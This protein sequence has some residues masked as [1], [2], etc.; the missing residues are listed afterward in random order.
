MS[1]LNYHHLHYFWTVARLGSVAAAAKELF[2]SQPTISAQVKALESQLGQEL[3]QRRGRGLVLTD[4]GKVAFGYADEIFRLGRELQGQMSGSARGPSRR[5]R[6][7]A[8][9]VEVLPKV[10]AE[11]LLQPAVE[12]VPSLALECREGALPDLLA[13]LALHEVDVVLSDTAATPDVRV[14]VFNHLLGET[15][16][17]F[18]GTGAFAKLREGFPRSMDGAPILLPTRASHLRRSV[19]DWFAQLGVEAEIVGE[20]DDSALLTVFGQR[21]MGIFAVPTAIEQSVRRSGG[22][23][24]SLEV[25]GRTTEVVERYWAISAER[26]LRHPAVAA[27]VEAARSRLFAR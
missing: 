16:L 19:D 18:L 2:V 13:R 12:S 1:W 4:A 7:T 21:G 6:L 26:R 20:F 14:K 17:T 22:D 23:G 8:G 25:L 27:V 15:G 5:T 10:V 24:E 9:I 11:R 3:F